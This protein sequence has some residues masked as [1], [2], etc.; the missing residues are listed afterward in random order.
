VVAAGAA[1]AIADK[2]LAFRVTDGNRVAVTTD[3]TGR[4]GESLVARAEAAERRQ[5]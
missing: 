1:D 3:T 4:I 2:V 5:L